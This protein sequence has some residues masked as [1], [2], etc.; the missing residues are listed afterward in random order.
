MFIEG[1]GVRLVDAHWERKVAEGLVSETPEGLSVGWKEY[2]QRWGL[3]YN[4]EVHRAFQKLLLERGVL[5]DSPEGHFLVVVQ[6]LQWAQPSLVPVGP[7][8]TSVVSV[9]TVLFFTQ[10]EYAQEWVRAW[11]DFETGQYE[12]YILQSSVRVH[13]S[14]VSG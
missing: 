6:P 10:L 12:Y 9:G 4:P 13:R 11:P 1:S 3:A 7:L 5:S 14:T 8:T 2:W